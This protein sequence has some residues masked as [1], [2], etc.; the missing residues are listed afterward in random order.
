MAFIRSRLRMPDSAYEL[1]A[2]RFQA[3]F[4]YKGFEIRDSIILWTPMEPLVNKAQEE[5][6]EN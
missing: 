6:V 3:R 2:V 4:V 5:S 1:H